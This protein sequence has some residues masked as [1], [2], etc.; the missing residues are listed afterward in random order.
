MYQ[1]IWIK[2]SKLEKFTSILAVGYS[3][4]LRGW[5]TLIFFITRLYF[6]VTYIGYS[7]YFP[8]VLSITYSFPYVCFCVTDNQCICFCHI[9]TL[10]IYIPETTL[11]KKNVTLEIFWK[12]WW[13]FGNTVKNQI[14]S[15]SS[16]ESR[17]RAPKPECRKCVFYA[18]CSRLQF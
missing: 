12:S 15:W 2:T 11:Y 17:S 10:N 3:H 18:S 4:P 8:L 7:L 1:D 5:E 16:T 14:V 6:M 9:I 13:L